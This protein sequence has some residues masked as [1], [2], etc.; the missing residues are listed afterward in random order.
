MKIDEAFC[1]LKSL[2]GFRR[3]VL[4]D[5]SPERIELLWLLGVMSIGLSLLLDEKSGYRWAKH[6]ND[7][8]KR[9]SL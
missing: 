8:R 9:C 7:P 4:T 3:L 2:F 1:D 5:N 6:Q